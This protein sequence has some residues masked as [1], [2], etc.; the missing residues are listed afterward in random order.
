MKN[1]HY[2]KSSNTSLSFHFILIFIFI[3]ISHLQTS[4]RRI[5]PVGPFV[6][7]NVFKPISA[8]SPYMEKKKKKKKGP[9]IKPEPRLF[10]RK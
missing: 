9:R 7:S 2:S 4:R 8:T 5:S 3:F 1:V 6:E 10:S